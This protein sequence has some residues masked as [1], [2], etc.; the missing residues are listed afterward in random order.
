M[1]GIHLSR[2]ALEIRVDDEWYSHLTLVVA[3]ADD[4]SFFGHLDSDGI[5]LVAVFDMIVQDIL[6]GKVAEASA[7]EEKLMPM[8]RHLGA[9]ESR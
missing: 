6:P 7:A 2:E 5:L 3:E 1:A 8:L 9:Q 4:G